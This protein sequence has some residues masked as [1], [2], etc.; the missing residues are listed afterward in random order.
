MEMASKLPPGPR[1]PGP[2]AT[3]KWQ[4]Y[5]VALLE[6]ALER[7]GHI[8][9]LR[10]VG[11]AKFVLISDPKM[12]EQVFT[13]DPEIIYGEARL[14]TPLLGERS[15]LILNGSEHRAMR[16]VLMPPFHGERVQRYRELMARI[17]EGELG[18][19]PLREPL[20]LLPRLHNITLNVIMTAIFGVTEVARQQV[21]RARILELL[22]WAVSPWR[23]ARHQIAFMRGWQPP[24]SFRQVRAPVDALVFEEIDRS[25]HDP[26]LEE[27]DDILAMLVQARHE[28][29][30]ALTDRELRDQLMTL[31]IQGHTSTANGIGWVLERVLRHPD[32]YER[33]RAEAQTPSEEYL[34]AVVKETLRV[35]PPLPFPMRRVVGQP[36]PLGGYEL[37]PDVMIASNGYILHRREDLYPEADRFRPERFLEQ[38]PGRHT[39]IPFGGGERACIGAAFALCEIKVVVR[40]LLQRT[41]LAPAEQEDEE[42]VR[43]GVGFAPAQGVRAVVQERVP[44]PAEVPA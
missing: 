17:C 16:N 12:I 30:S 31:L 8:W 14:A 3:V 32:V 43:R 34:D 41:R 36:F 19:W 9:T 15:V 33:L 37:D 4:R 27:R 23:M 5:P 29:G 13:A 1:D 44:A 42:I 35:R 6:S 11:G 40:T 21:L 18:T 10:L 22:E 39:W 20:P 7:F 2:L 24:R 28:D 26:R 25:R 38:S